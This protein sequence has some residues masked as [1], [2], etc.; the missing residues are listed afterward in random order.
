[1]DTM[2]ADTSSSIPM[3]SNGSLR[4]SKSTSFTRSTLNLECY[5]EEAQRIRQDAPATLKTQDSTFCDDDD[6]EDGDRSLQS[7]LARELRVMDSG[8]RHCYL[9]LVMNSNLDY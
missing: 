1:M 7:K 6:R 2:S 8:R 3:T 5:W 9:E 4:D